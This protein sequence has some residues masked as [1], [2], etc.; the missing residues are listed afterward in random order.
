[1]AKKTLNI[2]EHAKQVGLARPDAGLSVP[3]GYFED[4]ETKMISSLPYREEAESSEII[5]DKRSFWS[6]IRPYVYM[7]AMFAGVW[8]MLQMFS[9]IANPGKLQPMDSNPI[10]AEALGNEDFVFEYFYD[11]YSTEDLVDEFLETTDEGD[12]TEYFKDFNYENINEKSA[13]LP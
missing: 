9:M 11:D 3:E 8:L 4:F 10:L 5:E 7:A 6:T 1:M 13:I 2:L 12:C